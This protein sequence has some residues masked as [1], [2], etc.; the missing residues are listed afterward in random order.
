M[1]YAAI[2]LS[3][4]A[5]A[6]GAV[7]FGQ[8]QPNHYFQL[9]DQLI[10]PPKQPKVLSGMRVLRGQPVIQIVPKAPVC[11]IP[12]PNALPA[13][14]TA[15]FKTPV[16]KPPATDTKAIRIPMPVCASK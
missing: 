13:N 8:S 5:V 10:D 16:I 6:F 12:L 2:A 11:A 7:A 3:V 4:G 1:R 9:P 14:G 15:R